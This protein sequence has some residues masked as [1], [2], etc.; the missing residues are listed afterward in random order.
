MRR[1]T[2]RSARSR[3]AEAATRARS[4]ETAARARP[5]EA[6]SRRPRTRWA[7]FARACLADGEVPALERLRVELLDDLI[8]HVSIRELD[9]GEAA[10]A[11]GLSIDR[12]DDMR[13]FRDCGEVGAEV[14]F[15][16]RVGQ[17][18]NEQTDWHSLP[19]I[20]TDSIPLRCECVESRA[21][22]MR[23]KTSAF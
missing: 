22:P 2:A 5:A 21:T 16:R 10:W 14:G 7:I 15:G 6:T 11:P 19:L 3:A 12:H 8:R 1:W 13:R 4:A 17:V 9:E 23:T 20:P 18:S